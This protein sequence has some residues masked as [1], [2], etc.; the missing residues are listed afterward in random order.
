MLYKKQMGFKICYTQRAVLWDYN[1]EPSNAGDPA[2][3]AGLGRSPWRR[4]WQPTPVFLPGESHGQRSLVDYSPRCCK[5]SD[6]TEW[7]TL[8]TEAVFYDYY[9]SIF[10]YSNTGKPT[11]V[12]TKGKEVEWRNWGETLHNPPS[13]QDSRSKAGLSW[14]NKNILY[15]ITVWRFGI[16]LD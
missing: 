12:A 5:E 16:R 10:S 2:S 14:V 1:S 8:L 15:W 13:L 9:F 3:I 4:A 7:L 11:L 6:T